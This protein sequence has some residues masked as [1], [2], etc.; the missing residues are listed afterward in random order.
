MENLGIQLTYKVTIT[1]PQ[2]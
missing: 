1:G 2:V